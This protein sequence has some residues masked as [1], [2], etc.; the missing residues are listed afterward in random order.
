MNKEVDVRKEIR[1][2]K[3]DRIEGIKKESKDEGIVV[4]G[5]KKWIKRKKKEERS[6]D[7]LRNRKRR[8][9]VKK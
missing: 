9:Q 8:R 6:D 5:M 4:D 1:K 2:R 3:E 7:R